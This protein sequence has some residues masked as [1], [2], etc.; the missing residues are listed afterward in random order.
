MRWLGGIRFH[1]RGESSVEAG[2]WNREC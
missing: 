2:E 1:D